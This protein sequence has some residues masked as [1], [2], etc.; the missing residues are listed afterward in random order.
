MKMRSFAIQLYKGGNEQ[1]FKKE[2][3]QKNKKLTP[4]NILIY[5]KSII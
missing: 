1:S 5:S 4:I 2:D 3:G